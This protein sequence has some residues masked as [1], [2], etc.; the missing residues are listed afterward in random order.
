MTFRGE[1]GTA[2]DVQAL[3]ALRDALVAMDLDDTPDTPT[4]RYRLRE[5]NRSGSTSFTYSDDYDALSNRLDE[6]VDAGCLAGGD[7]D[8]F[9]NS[10]GW[11][12]C[13]G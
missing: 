1:N 13:P 2:T 4:V 11:V 5:Y 6:G 9:V 8:E 7:I 3:R 12:V 10:M